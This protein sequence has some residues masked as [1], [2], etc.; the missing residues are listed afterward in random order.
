[1]KNEE[2]SS[3]PRDLTMEKMVLPSLENLSRSTAKVDLCMFPKNE[4]AKRVVI[5]GAGHTLEDAISEGFFKEDDFIVVN[6]G[7]AP[8]LLFEGILCDM[9]VVVDPAIEASRPIDWFWWSG[10]PIRV[11]AATT[12]KWNQTGWSDY[13]F[14][15]VVHNPEGDIRK[16]VFNR[17]VE[18]ADANVSTYV[19]MVGDVT[20]ASALVVDRMM[21]NGQLPDVPIVFV[22][23]DHG[24][25]GEHWR[26]L[27]FK[28]DGVPYQGKL[29]PVD[30]PEIKENSKI[31]DALGP[32]T[33]QLAEYDAQLEFI[34]KNHPH[35]KF[36][37]AYPNRLDQYM[38][39]WKEE[40]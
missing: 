30:M 31:C 7:S 5:C 11:V 3:K 4:K 37:T 10:V 13:Y 8:R 39:I 28:W 33:I 38:P 27:C 25:V 24:A 34:V 26:C 23:V 36:F 12:S 2:Q 21:Q 35:R 15:N 32:T 18:F 14:K 40:E 16:E 9:Y 6:Q 22:G 20:N 1:M 29:L 19:L 17:I